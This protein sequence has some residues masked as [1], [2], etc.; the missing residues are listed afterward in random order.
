VFANKKNNTLVYLAVK[1]YLNAQRQ[2]THSTLTQAEVSG[3]GRKPWKQKGTGRARAGSNR[4][5]LWRHGGVTFGPKPR[6]YDI[7]LP[8]GAVKKAMKVILSDRAKEGKVII[9]DALKI[10]K[11]RTKDMEAILK[12]LKVYGKKTLMVLNPYDKK[13]ALSARNI[14]NLKLKESANVYDVLN[15]DTIVLSKT[16]AKKFEE[17][18]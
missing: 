9:I 12:N 13:A 8:K 7:D 18:L 2:G 1:K 4:S 11:P 16:A 15:A 17:V 14:K 5:P 6:D 10:D 3:G